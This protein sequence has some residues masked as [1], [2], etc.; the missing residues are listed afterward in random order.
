MPIFDK[1]NAFHY[2]LAGL[3]TPQNDGVTGYLSNGEIAYVFLSNCKRQKT[4][5]N[6]R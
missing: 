6:S 2:F 4:E 3:K 1:P 5:R